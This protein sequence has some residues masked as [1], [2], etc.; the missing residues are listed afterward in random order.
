[1][2]EF[3]APANP[4]V[5]IDAK[6]AQSMAD[7]AGRVVQMDAIIAATGTVSRG[8]IRDVARSIKD[9]EQAIRQLER[10]V[11]RKFKAPA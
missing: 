10:L 2:P 11:N 7:L 3:T 5:G 9:I 1:M 6:L 8:E 4:K